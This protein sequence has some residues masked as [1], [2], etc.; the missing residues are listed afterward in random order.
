MANTIVTVN[1]SQ[2]IAPTPSDLQAKGALVTV[3]GSTEA[4]GSLTLVTELAE[5]TAIV[6]QPAANTSL[7][8]TTGTVTVTTAAAHGL[9]VGDDIYITIAGVAPTAYN[10]TY[11]AT[12]TATDEFTYALVSDPGSETVPGTY[13]PAAA[14]ELTAMGTTFFA[15]GSSQAVYVLELGA[16]ETVNAVADL[17]TYLTDNPNTLYSY[18]VPRDF[19]DEATYVTLVGLYTGTT[20]KTYFFTTVTTMNYADFVD[21][22]S[23]VAMVEAP[24]IPATEFSL[25]AMFYHTLNYAPSTSNKVPPTAFAYLFGV[26]AYPTAGNSALLATLKAAGVNVVGTGAEGGISN[27]VLFW[28]T[29]MDVRDF[30]YWYAVDWVQINLQIDLAN[31]IINGSNNPLAPLYYNQDGIN[32]LQA[33]AQGTVNRGITFGMV[34]GPAP[35][36]AVGFVTYV[37][38]NPS[39][40]PAGIY[41]GLSCTLTPARGFT[42]ITFNLVVSDFVA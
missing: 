11:L 3:G 6:R 39:D 34:L 15:Q 38:D 32:R 21:T 22:K 28:G 13:V 7:S 40:Y 20:K 9:P 18:L 33:R 30:T 5:L 26:T 25:A 36:A 27:K 19:A 31:E 17:A 10:G 41:N 14:A 42:S 35:V 37:A 23:V 8:W 2:V 1:V 4:A 16:Q 12:I 29:T 24:D